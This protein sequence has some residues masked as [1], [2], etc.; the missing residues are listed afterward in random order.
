MRCESFGDANL[1]CEDFYR[2]HESYH[3]ARNDDYEIVDS[4]EYF[5]TEKKRIDNFLRT[6]EEWLHTFES[7]QVRLPQESEVRPNDSVSNVQAR[8]CVN[9]RGS[10]V[11]KK[12]STLSARLAVRVRKAALGGRKIRIRSS[13]S[14]GKGKT[15]N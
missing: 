7:Q 4:E 15:S 3:S 8:S 14:A 1:K 13:T 9:S 11:S 5:E 2:A 6:L 10:K 12:S